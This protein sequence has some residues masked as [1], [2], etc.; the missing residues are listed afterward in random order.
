MTIRCQKMENKW[1]TSGFTGNLAFTLQYLGECEQTAT[2]FREGLKLN[3]ELDTPQG[4][5][6]H[7]TGLAWVAATRAA[8]T[9]SAFDEHWAAGQ[10]MSLADTVTEAMALPT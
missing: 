8:L 9:P 2:L 4:A 5:A 7:L 10:A 1:F 3:Q 6:L